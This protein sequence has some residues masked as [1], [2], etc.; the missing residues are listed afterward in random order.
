MPQVE[1]EVYH[2]VDLTAPW[3]KDGCVVKVQQK[4]R[5]GGA[6]G[7]SLDE[8]PIFAAS[9]GHSNCSEPF[10]TIANA[11]QEKLAIL[12]HSEPFESP[13]NSRCPLRC[14]NCAHALFQIKTQCT[15]VWQA[16][17][18]LCRAHIA[19]NGST[20]GYNGE[21]TTMTYSIPELFGIG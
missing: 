8:V 19:M 6:S 16:F 2:A 17:L 7:F 15:Q 14:R 4:Q 5:A 1:V 18:K 21:A 12:N 3:G 10:R 9:Q 20:S 13:S 11:H